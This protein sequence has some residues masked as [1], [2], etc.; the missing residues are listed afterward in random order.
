M[1]TVYLVYF[2]CF[3]Y[4][5]FSQL[6]NQRVSRLYEDSFYRDESYFELKYEKRVTPGKDFKI[7]TQNITNI[8]EYR[9]FNPAVQFYKGQV[10]MIIRLNFLI[11]DSN[12]NYKN[13]RA[14][15]RKN[16]TLVIGRLEK[17]FNDHEELVCMKFYKIND[18]EPF[19][20]SFDCEMIPDYIDGG[21]GIQDPRL[22]EHHNKFYLLFNG[23][24]QF[25]TRFSSCGDRNPKRGIY[26]A[27]ITIMDKTL[28][29][30]NI[31]L[32][33]Y[34]NLQN[35]ERNWLPI[36]DEKKLLLV[37]SFFPVMKI[38]ELEQKNESELVDFVE[39]STA[40]ALDNIFIDIAAE[41]NLSLLDAKNNIQIHGSSPIL[42]VKDYLLG[43]V[44]CHY[45]NELGF[46]TYLNY[47]FKSDPKTFEIIDSARKHLPLTDKID[48]KYEILNKEKWYFES[49]YPMGN[50]IS[51]V[52]DMTI[53]R[54]ELILAYGAGDAES[55]IFIVKIRDLDHYFTD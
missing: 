18:L 50:S 42:L 24:R 43:V 21:H 20:N 2:A 53:S 1:I 38:L 12:P 11:R 49:N 28:K 54:Q 14:E 45:K 33:N 17:E 55:R 27:H 30:T 7:S 6:N 23:R 25:Q 52:S 40:D 31:R 36:Q 41:A 9:A 10:F 19:S 32:L 15:W 13:G 5:V 34:P 47:F 37:Y 8:K 39:I 48:K 3:A 26:L 44:H 16:N 22:F 4:K 29:L 35:I 51:F 46:R